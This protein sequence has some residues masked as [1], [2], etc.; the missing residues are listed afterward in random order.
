MPQIEKVIKAPARRR[1]APKLVV[2]VAPKGGV[3]KTTLTMSM[4]VSARRSGLSV[5]GVNMDE[6]ASLESWSVRRRRTI[7]RNPT[8]GIPEIQV[9]HLEPGDWRRLNDVRD[10]DIVI[11]DTPPGH[12]DA[13]HALRSLCGIAD[14][15]L[16]PTS[17]NG[18]D[19]EEIIPFGTSLDAN[20]VVFVLNRVNR[21]TRSFGQARAELL[22]EGH[23]C[24]VDIPLLEAIPT[25]YVHG[26]ATTDYGEAGSE[27]F[28]G[29]WH[30]VRREVG[31]TGQ[32]VHA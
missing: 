2:V 17:P 23:L 26:L 11:V 18:L 25:Q 22:K 12:G 30:F 7:E 3:G 20:K 10:Y 14:L 1:S 28:E 4:L 32:A 27:A 6:Q 5:L 8:H 24:P 19:L 9:M 29:L 21:R 13:M 16:I 15:V 31:L